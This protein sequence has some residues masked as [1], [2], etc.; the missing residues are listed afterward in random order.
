MESTADQTALAEETWLEVIGGL[1]LPPAHTHTTSHPP[2]LSS[3][4]GQPGLVGVETSGKPCRV[5]PRRQPR[6]AEAQGAGRH[7]ASVELHCVLDSPSPIWVPCTGLTPALQTSRHPT[8]R[9]GFRQNRSTSPSN[10]IPRLE[11][12][13]RQSQPREFD[14][15]PTTIWHPS[16]LPLSYPGLLSPHLPPS[17][18]DISLP[19]P[20]TANLCPFG[21]PKSPS[22][23]LPLLLLLL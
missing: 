15:I 4:R 3:R 13:I 20:P 1:L 19:T 10:N 6:Q 7:F 16:R 17:P 8:L 11:T 21:G 18:A 23:S 5:E 22:K 12:S 14:C 9:F 2:L